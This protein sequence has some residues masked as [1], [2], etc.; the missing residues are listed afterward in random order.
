METVPLKNGSTELKVAVV[1]AM[2]SIE[3]LGPIEQYELVM[4]ARDPK[5]GPWGDTVKRLSAMGL[6]ADNGTM[7]PTIR[8]VVLSAFSGEGLDI[9]LGS[10]IR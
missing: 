3:A 4:L 5:H 9:V 6:V 8:N 1:A 10:P 7:H 2:V